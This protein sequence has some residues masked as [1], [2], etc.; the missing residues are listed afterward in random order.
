MTNYCWNK[1]HYSNEHCQEYITWTCFLSHEPN[2]SKHCCFSSWVCPQFSFRRL[3]K[4]ATHVGGFATK[5]TEKNRDTHNKEKFRDLG[6]KK[7]TIQAISVYLPKHIS[8][9]KV[10]FTKWQTEFR[11]SSVLCYIISLIL[12]PAVTA[13]INQTWTNDDSF[14]L[15]ALTVHDIFFLL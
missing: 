14:D 6:G 10:L 15:S 3:L 5:S 9:D 4:Q 13:S 12:L 8:E 2:V 1:S 7:D 11:V